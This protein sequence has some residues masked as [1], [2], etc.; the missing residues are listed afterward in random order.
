V[1]WHPRTRAGGLN[2]LSYF[3]LFL[4][5]ERCSMNAFFPGLS[6][7]SRSQPLV[8]T[9]ELSDK[10]LDVFLGAAETLEHGR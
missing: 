4:V 8:P 3:D 5:R 7:M 10:G 9:R 2:I 1:I 6:S